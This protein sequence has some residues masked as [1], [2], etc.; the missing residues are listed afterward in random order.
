[1]NKKEIRY[2]AAIGLIALLVAL[3]CRSFGNQLIETDSGVFQ[4]VATEMQHGKMP[5]L[6]TFDHKGP[7]QYA[8]NLLGLTISPSFGIWLLE[9]IT[10]GVSFLFLY[11][12]ARL[13]AEPLLSLLAVGLSAIAVVDN[14]YGGNLTEEY[15]LPL[16]A[17]SLYIFLKYFI[18]GDSR[19]W[20]VFWCGFCFG[21]VLLLRPNM[22]A[23]WI[24]GCFLVLIDC[25]RKKAYPQL[26]GFIGAFLLGAG[27]IL[28]PFAIWLWKAGALRAAVDA[29]ILFNMKYNEYGV[30]LSKLWNAFSGLLLQY[31]PM[32]SLFGLV[33]MAFEDRSEKFFMIALSWVLAAALIVMPGKKFS[34]YAAVLIPNMAYTFAWLLSWFAARCE[35]KTKAVSLAFAALLFVGVIPILPP[36]VQLIT[37]QITYQ[38]GLSEDRVNT[39]SIVE[40]ILEKST[41]EDEITV[42]GNANRY[43]LLSNR[44][45]ASRYSYQNPIDRVDPNI[46][47]YYFDDLEENNP[48]VIVWP[49]YS[50]D[51]GEVKEKMDAFIQTHGY[52]QDSIEECVFYLP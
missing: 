9:W 5:Y 18:D 17:V 6:D 2:Y 26:L 51:E 28:L 14:V 36:F 19:K 7:L 13:C 37:T 16:I 23:V 40:R 1:M 27:A 11:R 4:Y 24:A 38:T 49:R 33:L 41:P 15:A 50:T 44:M 29:Y 21:G 42:Y 8:I 48:K 43:Y 47:W 45:S 52:V 39:D 12:I 31:L 34:H 46:L 20:N 3:T 10:F 25:I 22:I 30:S 35:I 32:L